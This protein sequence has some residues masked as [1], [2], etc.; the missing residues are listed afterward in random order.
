[1]L[2]VDLGPTKVIWWSLNVTVFGNKVIADVISEDEV[3]LQGLG[4]VLT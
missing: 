2:G 3:T 1:M 4:R